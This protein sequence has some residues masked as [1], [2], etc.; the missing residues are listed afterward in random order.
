MVE[1]FKKIP[2]EISYL[3]V[4]AETRWE[5]TPKLLTGAGSAFIDA[6]SK[7]A[8]EEK[9]EEIAAQVFG[10]GGKML[11]PMVKEAYNIPVEDAIGALMLHWL[12]GFL[13]TGPELE[14]ENPEVTR[15]KCVSRVTKCPWM[16]R[17]KEFG[18]KFDCSSFH[19]AWVD[20][21]LKAINS[22]VTIKLTTAL[23][24]G[25]PYCESVHE[26]K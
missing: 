4:P 15:E 16:E 1:I 6:I 11:F 24:R 19:Q 14:G 22:K 13:V 10:I 8:G 18:L 9:S 3:G 25:D 5:I 7:I 26:L 2:A 21:G 23:P 20:E 17:Q 12:A